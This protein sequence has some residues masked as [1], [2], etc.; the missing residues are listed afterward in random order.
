MIHILSI[1]TVLIIY[2]KLF[3]GEADGYI[4]MMEIITGWYFIV[5]LYHAGKLVCCMIKC[6]LGQNIM[7]SSYLT[8]PLVSGG[9]G[10]SSQINEIFWVL[11]STP[12]ETI[13]FGE[14]VSALKRKNKFIIVALK[15]SRLPSVNNKKHNIFLG[16]LEK[17]YIQAWNN[18]H[19][20]IECNLW[21]GKEIND[22]TET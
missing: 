9:W 14:Y 7:S 12:G 13:T 6:L 15:F 20:E 11:P 5:Q 1:T 2:D 22:S 8:V 21:S 3:F 19:Q 4:K 16:Q 10:C 17:R 18:Y